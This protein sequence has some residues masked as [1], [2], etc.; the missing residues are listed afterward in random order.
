MIT[1]RKLNSD[2]IIIL[3]NIVYIPSTSVVPIK[4]FIAVFFKKISDARS[5]YHSIHLIVTSLWSVT[6]LFSRFFFVQFCRMSHNLYSRFRLRFL[7]QILP[8]G[9]VSFSV[10]HIKRCVRNVRLFHYWWFYVWLLVSVRFFH[11]EGVFSLFN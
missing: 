9:F 3:C 11:C 8:K 1:L 2:I 6:H 4:S 5:I 10:R 7:A